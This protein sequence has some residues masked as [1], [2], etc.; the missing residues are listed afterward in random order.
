MCC[1]AQNN[2]NY[3]Y[4]PGDGTIDV[5]VREARIA[6]PQSPSLQESHRLFRYDKVSFFHRAKV[7]CF[8]MTR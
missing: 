3:S 6:K 4:S 7:N 5:R 1:V 2:G 8:A